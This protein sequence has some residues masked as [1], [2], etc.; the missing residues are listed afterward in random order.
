MLMT[1]NAKIVWQQ[2]KVP[3]AIIPEKAI[4]LHTLEDAGIL[5]FYQAFLFVAKTCQHYKNLGGIPNV[6]CKDIELGVTHA[7]GIGIIKT[8]V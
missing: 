4:I 3:P 6:T 5:P 7:S 1:K 2:K 8:N